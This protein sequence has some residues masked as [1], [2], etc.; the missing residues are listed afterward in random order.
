MGAY[1]NVLRQCHLITDGDMSAT[2]ITSSA[3][4]VANLDNI[5]IQFIW[6][7]VA[8]GVFTLTGSIDGTTYSA[9]PST[10]YTTL[11]VPSGSPS[12]GFSFID[13]FP[14]TY[15]KVTYTKTSDTG[16]LNVWISGKSI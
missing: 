10:Y 9:I 3:V 7:G 6:T 16:T 14:I 12:N 8:V 5:G 1:K 2:A 13:D 15:L 4:D 11:P